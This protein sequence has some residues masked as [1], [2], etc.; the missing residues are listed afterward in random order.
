MTPRPSEHL[1]LH[2]QA[3]SDCGLPDVADV[4]EHLFVPGE[5]LI[6]TELEGNDRGLA[7][8]SYR[9]GAGFGGWGRNKAFNFSF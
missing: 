8:G 5:V 4:G 6:M 9:G 3:Q 2:L 1:P 7:W